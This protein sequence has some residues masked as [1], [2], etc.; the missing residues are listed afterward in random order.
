[1]QERRLEEL[2][3]RWDAQVD[4]GA[5]AD[6]RRAALDALRGVLQERSYIANL[7]ANVNRE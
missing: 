6:E 3:G 1:M 4:R 5:S 2:C 7:L